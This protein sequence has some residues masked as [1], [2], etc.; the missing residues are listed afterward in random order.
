MP[1]EG[2]VLIACPPSHLFSCSWGTHTLIVHSPSLASS[3]NCSFG[4]S[5]SKVIIKEP[6]ILLLSKLGS[7]SPFFHSLAP[8]LVI[9]SREMCTWGAKW[10]RLQQ[11]HYS[12]SA[13]CGFW[14]ALVPEA[15]GAAQ[16]QGCSKG[17][18]LQDNV[19]Q[20]HRTLKIKR[21]PNT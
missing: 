16:E 14:G 2:F 8:G 17:Q 6:L 20:T 15:R 4:K 3:V 21:K 5:T 19:T 11:D 18:H 10:N 13:T 9:L 7:P 1:L 12:Q